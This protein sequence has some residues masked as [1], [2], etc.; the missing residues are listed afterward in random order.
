MFN[1][2]TLIPTESISS[3]FSI[4]PKPKKYPEDVGL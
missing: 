3:Y 1:F 4:E 2:Y